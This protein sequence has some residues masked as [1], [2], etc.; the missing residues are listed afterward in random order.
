MYIQHKG[1]KTLP[2]FRIWNG[3]TETTYSDLNCTYFQLNLKILV[4]VKHILYHFN[5]PTQIDQ[6]LLYFCSLC[7][8]RDISWATSKILQQTT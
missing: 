3:F 6:E 7:K 1:M 5:F 4:F 8:K 2:L